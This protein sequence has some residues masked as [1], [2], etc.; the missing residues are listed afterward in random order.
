[1]KKYCIIGTEEEVGQDKI[2]GPFESTFKDEVVATFDK[3]ED[4]L[5]YLE[6]SRLKNIKKV[7]Y[8]PDVVFKSKSLL[9]GF[10]SAHVALYLPELPP[11]HNP[12]L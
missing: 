12:K 1:M 10:V 4:A 6:E 11:P 9:R 3:K 2:G 7:T 8:G 5:T